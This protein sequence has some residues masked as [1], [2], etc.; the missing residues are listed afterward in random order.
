MTGRRTD[1]GTIRVQRA[2]AVLL[3]GFGTIGGIAA[4]AGATPNDKVTLC[5]ATSSVSNPYTNPTVD[6]SA[7]AE[8]NNPGRNGHDTHVNDIIPPF[9]HTPVDYPGKNWTTANQTIWANGCAA[10]PVPTNPPPTNPPTNQPTTNQPTTNQ[11]TTNQ[12]TANQPS[13]NQP[14]GNQPSGNQTLVSFKEV[15][16]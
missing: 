3:I 13:G 8:Q 7:V 2:I 9:T 12:P 5:H 4:V 15:D 10:V 14:S 1:A 6:K 16:I 11:P